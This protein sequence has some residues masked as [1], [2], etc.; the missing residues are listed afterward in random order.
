MTRRRQG[1]SG[2]AEVALSWTDEKG[3]ARQGTVKLAAS[4]LPV[5]RAVDLLAAGA[6]G[7]GIT[8]ATDAVQMAQAP[9]VETRPGDGRRPHRPGDPVRTRRVQA[10]REEAPRG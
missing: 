4:G 3:I 2:V 9:Q 10:I 1:P 6:T 5:A 7:A 8:V